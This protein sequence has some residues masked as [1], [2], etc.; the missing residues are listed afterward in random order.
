M[1]NLELVLKLKYVP[2]VSSHVCNSKG[3]LSPHKQKEHGKSHTR[4]GQLQVAS[5][6]G[7]EGLGDGRASHA[8][9]LPRLMLNR[10]VTVFGYG[11]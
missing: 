5:P 3:V 8:V 2:A 7:E 6:G 1:L 10:W 11:S 9:P 4:Q